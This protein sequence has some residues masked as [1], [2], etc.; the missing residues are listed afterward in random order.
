MLV[1]MP[2]EC[3]HFSAVG[4]LWYLYNE[5]Q[6]V[7]KVAT[8]V[9]STEI[10]YMGQTKVVEERKGGRRRKEREEPRQR[11]V[12]FIGGGPVIPR[13]DGKALTSRHN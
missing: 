3:S 5:L 10:L 11:R 1:K 9:D 8:P 4:F 13:K 2:P 12:G 6:N 7:R